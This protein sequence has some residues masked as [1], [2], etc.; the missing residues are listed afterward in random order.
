MEYS[1]IV[2]VSLLVLTYTECSPPELDQAAYCSALNN[3]QQH[4]SG[5]YRHH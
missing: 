1:Y 2:A 4:C 5:I 3:M